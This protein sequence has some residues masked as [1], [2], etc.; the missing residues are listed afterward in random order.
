MD[1]KKRL[2]Q[3]AVGSPKNEVEGLDALHPDRLATMLPDQEG[4]FRQAQHL[5]EICDD[6]KRRGAGGTKSGLVGIRPLGESASKEF[7]EKFTETDKIAKRDKKVVDIH[8]DGK[9]DG[10]QLK[11]MP[12]S[13]RVCI[14]CLDQNVPP[15]SAQ[16]HE[17][18]HPKETCRCPGLNYH[19]IAEFGQ[20]FGLPRE[21]VIRCVICF[22]C[23]K[24]RNKREVI[25]LTE[26][27]ASIDRM[28]RLA[29][30]QKNLT[31]LLRTYMLT[32]A[33]RVY[34]NEDIQA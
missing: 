23:R 5:S 1:S 32:E 22:D 6:T 9:Y 10:P 8:G 11:T 21:T 31:T 18:K 2:K 28:N 16:C 15:P 4:E 26:E 3:L 20:E 25:V 17:L 13:E 19:P 7:H 14:E 24:K 27:L 33:T 29:L 30:H 34:S 12:F